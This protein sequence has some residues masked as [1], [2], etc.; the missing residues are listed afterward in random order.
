MAIERDAILNLTLLLF[1]MN[2]KDVLPRLE[3]LYSEKTTE[4]FACNGLIDP[5]MPLGSEEIDVAAS[6]DSMT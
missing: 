5:R 3:N 6:L 1:G 2:S 4:S